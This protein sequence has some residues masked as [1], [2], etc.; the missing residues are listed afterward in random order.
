LDSFLSDVP[1][2]LTDTV[3]YASIISGRDY[4]TAIVPVTLGGERMAYIGPA[5]P[6]RQTDYRAN[7][8]AV[9]SL[10]KTIDEWCWV[11]FMNGSIPNVLYANCGQFVGI[12]N[13]SSSPIAQAT[14]YTTG[15]VGQVTSFFTDQQWQEIMSANTLSNSF[16]AVS[17]L[18]SPIQPS[19][20]GLPTYT[21]VPKSGIIYS[22]FIGCSTEFVNFTYTYV[23]GSIVSADITPLDNL[24]MFNAIFEPMLMSFDPFMAGGAATTAMSNDAESALENWIDALHR[25]YFSLA[26][27]ATEEVDNIDQQERYTRLVARIP[28]AP[29]FT[30]GMLIVISIIFNVCVLVNSLWKT[31]LGKTHSKQ[32]IVSIAGLAANTFEGKAANDL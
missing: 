3:N 17:R 9:R 30:L 14:F 27:I 16:Y 15:V 1:P 2:V 24:D 22:D 18:D 29:L 4:Y 23:N 7:T 28:K 5:N 12:P 31:S 21:T 26:A 8:F 25:H 10:C 11:R 20:N 19:I 13:D 6:H 32:V